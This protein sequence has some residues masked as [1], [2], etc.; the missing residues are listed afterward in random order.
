MLQKACL[1]KIHK[2]GTIGFVPSGAGYEGDKHLGKIMTLL[3]F[4][5]Y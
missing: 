5:I 2:F 3:N 1:K 4:L